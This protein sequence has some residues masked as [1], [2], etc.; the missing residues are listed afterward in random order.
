MLQAPAATT[1]TAAAGYYANGLN[2]VLASLP[3]LTAALA[4]QQQ[5]ASSAATAAAAA[6][7]GGGGGGIF[8]TQQAGVQS[9]PPAMVAERRN[10]KG[11]HPPFAL[12]I[13]PVT[14]FCGRLPM[15]SRLT[16]LGR[17]WSS[18]GDGA[19]GVRG[20]GSPLVS[21]LSGPA[22]SPPQQLAAAAA[23]P[24][25]AGSGA[26]TAAAE[27]AVRRAY[28]AALTQWQAQLKQLAAEASDGPQVT[29][30]RKAGTT[31]AR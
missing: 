2:S 19:G 11:A 21:G 31:D 9:A 30:L 8:G 18:A 17:R 5:Q 15:N 24:A 26:S 6:L 3:A 10:E 28:D 23:A 16:P 20:A 1:T 27:E 13:S 12:V 25:G 7:S 4:A 14:D 29:P 22:A